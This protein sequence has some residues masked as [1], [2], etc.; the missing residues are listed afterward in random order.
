MLYRFDAQK[1]GPKHVHFYSKNKFEKFLYLVGFI[2]RIYHDA[3][4]CECQKK[5]F[6]LYLNIFKTILMVQL[7]F[8]NFSY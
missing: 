3:R 2:I 7:T 5:N 8:L 1:S 6:S 4:S